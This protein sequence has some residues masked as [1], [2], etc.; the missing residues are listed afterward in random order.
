MRTMLVELCARFGIEAIVVGAILVDGE[1]VSASKIRRYIE[2]G[3]VQEAARMLGR[4]F[5]IDFEVVGGQH[6]GRLLGTPTINQPL[7][8]TLSVPGSGCTPPAWR[9]TARSPT[10]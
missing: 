4:P 5:T 3:E 10:G 6:L 7:P 8:R 9:W 1:P 2:Q